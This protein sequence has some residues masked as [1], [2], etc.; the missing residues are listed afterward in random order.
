MTIQDNLNRIQQAKSDIKAA[1]E[2]KGVYV[3]EADK[4]DIYASKIYEIEQ[5]GGFNVIDII[6]AG[7]LYDM[8][9]NQGYAGPAVLKGTIT[10]I[11]VI[12]PEYNNATYY[13][14][15]EIK[16]YRGNYLEGM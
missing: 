5:G 13:I 6:D 2:S 11:E 10:G 9:M 3:D 1:I 4:I 7:Q 14:D 16:V 15:G 12:S 8:I